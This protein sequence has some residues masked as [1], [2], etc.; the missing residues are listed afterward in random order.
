MT[1]IGNQFDLNEEELPLPEN[2]NLSEWIS[3]VQS[4][5]RAVNVYQRSDLIAEIDSLEGQLKTL[6]SIPEGE[7]GLEEEGEE[8][9]ILERMLEVHKQFVASGITFKVQGRSEN[10]CAAKEKEWSGHRETN[11]KSKNEKRV[12]IQLHQLADSIIH[13][14]G[15][16][17]E[18][19]AQLREASE[20]Q[21]R[22]LLVAFS[23]ACNAQPKVTVPF[24]Q[25]SSGGKRTG[26][27]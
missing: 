21:I 23:L 19:L 27:R 2:F 22:K 24:S 26:S 9:D 13:P 17:Y 15:V 25:P 10:W 8:N 4:T 14:E 11:G 5:V 6:R 7:R 20:P 1:E 16:T 12:F 3:G 18:L